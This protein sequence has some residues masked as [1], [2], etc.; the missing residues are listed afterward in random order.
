MKPVRTLAAVASAGVLV[1][2]AVGYATLPRDSAD[3][4]V[5]ASAAA[6]ASP[7]GLD[8]SE[9]S[10]SVS[11]SKPPR[12]PKPTAQRTASPKP[13]ATSSKPTAKTPTST[14]GDAATLAC[15]RKHESTNNYRAVSSTGKFRG[16]YQFHQGY[17]PEWA[18]RYG[19]PEW[20]G[21]PSNLWPPRVQ[22]SIAY[23]MGHGN[24]Y[25]AWRN[26]TSYN[27]PGF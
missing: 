21:K 18:K 9:R 3:S 14:V 1:A 6:T 7:Y 27:C 16:A 8:R 23:Q 4:A 25:A 20:A 12:T 26:H 22:D 13:T 10:W 19:Y 5:G 2:S 15:I 17:A 11:R 24:R